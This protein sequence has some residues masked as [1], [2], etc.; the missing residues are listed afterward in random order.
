MHAALPYPL[1]VEE[2]LL[3]S[4]S[5][6][7]LP[8]KTIRELGDIQRLDVSS[9]SEAD[10][11][12]EIIDPIVRSL[13]YKKQS[14]FSLERE[15]PLK[16]LDKDLR[17]DY[18]FT[19]LHENFWVIEAKKVNRKAL[20]FIAAD[21][22]QALT[23]ASHPDINATLLVLCDGR[24]L[25]VFDREE[26]LTT[27][28]VELEIAN[29][30]RDFDKLRS[31]LSP[32]QS[33]FFEKRRIVRMIDKVFN[34]ELNMERLEEFR[35]LVNSRLREKRT[36]VL[37]N[38]QQ[39]GEHLIDQ[40]RTAYFRTCHYAEIIDVHFFRRWT[41]GELNAMSNRLTDLC[42]ED[43]FRILYKIFPDHP[44]DTNDLYWG[45]A[46]H[47]LLRLEQR[48][49]KVHW[50]PSY[51]QD[52]STTAPMV[53]R[54]IA[55]LID[56]CLSHFRRDKGRHVVQLYSAAA[57]RLTKQIILLSPE[58][59]SLAK[60]Q[61]ALLRHHLHEFSFSQYC[62]TPEGHCGTMLDVNTLRATEALIQEC[63]NSRDTFEADKA[64]NRLLDIWELE[65]RLLGDGKR[66][67]LAR[68][69]IPIDEMPQSECVSLTYDNLG[70]LCLCTIQDFP[71]WKE[72][73]LSRHALE[74][75]RLVRF[76]S[77]QA[78]EWLGTDVIV[79]PECATVNELAELFFF[80]DRDI[81]QS[82]TSG[83]GIA[84]G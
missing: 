57:R 24:I 82:L 31:I 76:R 27:P 47:F 6:A 45:A 32:W 75:Q 74:V 79:Q 81:L 19:L 16:I 51:L 37:Q 25:H 63:T 35:A 54:A 56:L 41:H 77:W 46:L 21:L 58:T 39:L 26:S 12:A 84:L 70:H 3:F 65:R 4:K 83:Y 11:R 15:K 49:I 20:R 34:R 72:H 80:G 9:F 67:Q 68:K 30:V 62:S 73:V 5:L 18:S 10:V 61:H 43:S 42:K 23:Y 44:R 55:R 14:Y 50:V 48:G 7:P 29:L 59:E 36:T 38:Y 13:G 28:I 60:V 33:W 2:H 64:H 69:A 8:E 52:E 66:Y 78:K 17:V 71:S 40:D 53:T 1:K 22:E